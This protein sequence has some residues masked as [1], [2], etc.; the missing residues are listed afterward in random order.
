MAPIKSK[1]TNKVKSFS[2][3][4]AIDTAKFFLI[5]AFIFGFIILFLTP[6]F[7][8]PDED[9][10][11]LRSNQIAHGNL[12]PDKKSDLIG[13]DT[14]KGT[15]DL[16]K[17][18]LDDPD[19]Q[20]KPENK[21][22]LSQ[23]KD[24]ARI[25]PQE[26]KT[27]FVNFGTEAN[28]PV[29]YI[30]PSIAISIGLLLGLNPLILLYLARIG[31]FLFW[32]GA[33]YTAIRIIPIKKATFAI[34][35]LVPMIIFQAGM[36]TSDSVAFAILSL[37]I[38][39]IIKIRLMSDTPSKYQWIFLAALSLTLALTK[40]PM[41]LFLPLILLSRR[42]TEAAKNR[43]LLPRIILAISAFTVALWNFYVNLNFKT[44]TVNK[45]DSVPSEQIS[46]LIHNPLVVF[47]LL[48]NTYITSTGDSI[49][50]SFIGLFGWFDT[51]LPMLFVALSALITV[52]SYKSFSSSSPDKKGLLVFRLNSREKLLTAVT[53]I[54]FFVAVN[55]ALYIYYT[56]PK[57]D[58]FY[59][60]QGRYFLPLLYVGLLFSSQ[61]NYKLE[62]NNYHNI[63]K[64]L[65]GT[66]TV[67]FFS[68]ITIAYRYYPI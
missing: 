23:F 25:Q 15:T 39:Q 13:G 3:A 68:V 63:S 67:L 41:F 60:V 47:K 59:G 4:I 62:N 52:L 9:I 18:A 29:S 21:I 32:L 16:I 24:A 50:R 64:L 19:M 12:I 35:S 44:N 14:S 33:T 48:Y 49:Y 65:V 1:V 27:K 46:Y 8:G 66:S 34:I 61:P 53:M 38:A 6:P 37:F 17:T 40:Q 31:G 55:L 5:S 51:P 11:Y 36:I 43:R 30:P 57:F 42:P 2:E 45:G 28:A 56:P 20:F 58:F 22:H 54:A 10:H 26:G 7:Q